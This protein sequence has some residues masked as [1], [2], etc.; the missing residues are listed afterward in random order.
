MNNTDTATP[1]LVLSYLGL[2]RAIGVLALCL[3][4]V[5]VIGKILL[6]S[7]GIEASISGYY[8][9]NVHTTH[10]PGGEIRGQVFA[11]PEGTFLPAVARN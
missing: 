2:R 11:T 7:P 10:H 6:Q 5:L 3:P 8:Y 1:S 9:T 4:F